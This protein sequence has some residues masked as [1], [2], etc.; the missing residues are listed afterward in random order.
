MELISETN[1]KYGGFWR[2]FVALIIDDIV[3]TV[4][5]LILFMIFAGDITSYYDYH[6]I[7]IESAEDLSDI[8]LYPFFISNLLYLLLEVAYYA[9]MHSSSKQATI[10]KMCLDMKVVDKDGNRISFLRGV[11]RYF[12][13]FLS[14]LILLI[15]YIMAAFDSKK[16]ALHDKLANTYVVVEE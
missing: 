11:G 5:Y 10:G 6:N 12:A 14:A 8:D 13:K 16:Q 15:G 4:V 7:S 1:Y 9:G 3:V 2:R